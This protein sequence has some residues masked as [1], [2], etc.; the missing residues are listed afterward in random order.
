[1]QLVEK[2]FDKGK[3][4]TAAATIAVRADVAKADVVGSTELLREV[5]ETLR[6]RAERVTPADGRIDVRIRVRT[7]GARRVAEVAVADG[8][9]RLSDARRAR[10]FEPFSD[11]AA[12]QEGTGLELA[13]AAGVVKS[14]G[15][16]IS[17][18]ATGEAGTT[19]VVRLPETAARTKE[20]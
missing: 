9:P 8:G 7:D 12:L 6:R 1:V 13:A 3:K 17:A 19:I 10:L 15:G 11:A 18:D 4:K 2:A 20:R 5:F 14:H 16:A